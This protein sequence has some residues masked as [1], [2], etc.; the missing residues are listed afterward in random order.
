MNCGIALMNEWKKILE[1]EQRSIF[2]VTKSLGIVPYFRD[3]L[4]MEVVG[5]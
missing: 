4:K 1:V 5:I 2:N 3:I